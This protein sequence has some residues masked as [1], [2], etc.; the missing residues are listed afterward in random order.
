[1]PAAGEDRPVR[2]IFAR[3]AYELY[4]LVRAKLIKHGLP[5]ED[6]A[7][8]LEEIT[9]RA[10]EPTPPEAL[11]DEPPA[12]YD[13]RLIFDFFGCWLTCDIRSEQDET[14]VRIARLET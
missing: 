14:I 7:L 5:D 11:I 4:E 1:M 6:I 12:G 13:R 8:R 2:R 10:L 3:R 9:T